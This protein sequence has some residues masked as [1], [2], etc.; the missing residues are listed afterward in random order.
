MD[1]EEVEMSDDNE[2]TN[3]AHLG[4]AKA[5]RE[6]RKRL[7]ELEGKV[8][9]LIG[10]YLGD[11]GGGPIADA[12]VLFHLFLR[13]ASEIDDKEF[14]EAIFQFAT[15]VRS[16]EIGEEFFRDCDRVRDALEDIEENVKVR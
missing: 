5:C 15:A 12:G 6:Q 7:R 8:L 11:E 16:L 13:I 9:A 4:D 1:S 10:E 14:D 2:P 3:L